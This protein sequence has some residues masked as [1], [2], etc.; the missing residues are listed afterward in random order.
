MGEEANQCAERILGPTV[1]LAT[2][3]SMEIRCPCLLYT[4]HMARRELPFL[5]CFA[6]WLLLVVTNC[7]RLCGPPARSWSDHSIISSCNTAALS[8]ALS[9]L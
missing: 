8:P 4:F 1:P 5:S 3:V 7:S 2:S 9:H 6:F